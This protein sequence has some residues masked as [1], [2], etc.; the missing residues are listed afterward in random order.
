MKNYILVLSAVLISAVSSFSRETFNLDRA[1][2]ESMIYISE[3]LPDGAKVAVLKVQSPNNDL[4]DYIR[5]ECENYIST[6]THL[7]LA[8][9][10]GLALI[11]RRKNIENFNDSD[12]DEILQAARLLGAGYAIFIEFSKRGENYRFFV[13]AFNAENSD[14]AGMQSLRVHLDEILADFTGEKY[15][16]PTQQRDVPT[17]DLTAVKEMLAAIDARLETVP[18]GTPQVVVIDRARDEEME[19]MRREMELLRAAIST[20]PQQQAVQDTRPRSRVFMSHRFLWAT[21][22][23][24]NVGSAP[25][26]GYEIEL[27]GLKRDK[28]ILSGTSL[29]AF[30]D[31][32]YYNDNDWRYDTYE[33]NMGWGGGIFIAPRVISAGEVFKFV[34]G[35]N[36]GFWYYVHDIEHYGEY[37]DSW[38]G[39]FRT[40]YHYEWADE[41]LWGGPDF[42]IMVGY[43]RVYLDIFYKMQMGVHYQRHEFDYDW[44]GSFGIK[45]LWGAGVSFAIGKGNWG[46]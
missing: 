38:S 23:M 40:G 37:W 36:V 34:P 11:L 5:V 14:I 18:A 33:F 2:S 26:R 46:K 20:A 25:M 4:S 3:K 9:K 13:Q 29:I 32:G 42:R 43:R 41:M 22:T 19:M 15:I 12:E 24:K 17:Q 44:W 35:I 1:I 8:D 6:N 31:M 45:H 16:P 30:G 7:T 39:T 10:R 21:P 28:L 27:G